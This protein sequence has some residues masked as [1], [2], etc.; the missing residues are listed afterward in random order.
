MSSVP[1]GSAALD[2]YGEAVCTALLPESAKRVQEHLKAQ[3]SSAQVLELP[4]GTRTAAEAAQAISE[5][6]SRFSMPTC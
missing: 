2:R 6:P 4:A 3:G 5:L 1:K